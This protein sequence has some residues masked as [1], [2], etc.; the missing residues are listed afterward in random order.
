M[1]VLALALGM[2]ACVAIGNFEDYLFFE[3]ESFFKGDYPLEK[4]ALIVGV[5]EELIKLLAVAVIAMISRRGSN[6]ARQSATASS[7]P[8]SQS[9]ITF[10]GITLHIP[11]LGIPAQYRNNHLAMR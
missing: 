10:R 5:C 6:N 7:I 4:Q 9:M 11:L 3:F 8:G 2:L 1:L